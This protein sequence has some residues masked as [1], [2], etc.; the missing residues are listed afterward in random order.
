[1]IEGHTFV[2]AYFTNNDRSI[3]ESLW[4]DP[5]GKITRPFYI[6]VNKDPDIYKEFLKSSLD[7]DEYKSIIKKFKSRGEIFAT[8]G[9]IESLKLCKKL[10]LNIYKVSSGLV[11][12]LALIREIAKTKM[13]IECRE[14]AH[15]MSG[16][17]VTRRV[18]GTGSGAVCV[19]SALAL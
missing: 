18:P 16:Y 9:D 15:G 10:N 8:P 13:P 5:T 7:F 3:L 11:N 2:D 19:M 1:M 4:L 14:K 6:E 12:N 17:G